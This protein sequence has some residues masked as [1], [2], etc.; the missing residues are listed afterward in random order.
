MRQNLTFPSK[1]GRMGVAGRIR[2]AS[3]KLPI[4]ERRGRVYVE[5]AT[6]RVLRNP[7]RDSS[8]AG[9]PLAGGV[10]TRRSGACFAQDRSRPWARAIW[11]AAPQGPRQPGGRF[12]ADAKRGAGKLRFNARSVQD[13]DDGSLH[14]DTPTHSVQAAARAPSVE[15][16]GR[17]P[18]VSSNK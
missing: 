3:G 9:P 10:E 15:L 11:P 7:R 6:I 14:P 17:L 13:A 5:S 2:Q 8:R 4:V 12:G 18:P 1:P 16:V